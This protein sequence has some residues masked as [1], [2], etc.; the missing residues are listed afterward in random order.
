[1]KR[2]GGI[3]I[4][5]SIVMI[6]EIKNYL[7]TGKLPE[8]LTDAG[9]EAFLKR[10]QIFTMGEDGSIRAQMIKDGAELC[11]VGDD[12]TET[13]Q[14]IFDEV[15]VENGHLKLYKTWKLI[16]EEWFG[17]KKDRIVALME[18]CKECMHENKDFHKENI[19]GNT[20][21]NEE[22]EGFE[23]TQDTGKEK[24][25]LPEAE[26]PMQRLDISLIN[27]AE[28]KDE[29]NGYSEILHIID[30]H[31]DY[32][33]VHPL[34]NC[35]DLSSQVA[36]G[37]ERIFQEEGRPQCVYKARSMGDVDIS[38]PE[39]PDAEPIQ[40]VQGNI[41][42]HVKEQYKNVERIFKTFRSKLKRYILKSDNKKTWIH[43]IDDLIRG[44]NTKK[45]PYT[46]I[47]P[48]MIFKHKVN[49]VSIEIKELDTLKQ[50][51]SKRYKETMQVQGKERM[52]MILDTQKRRGKAGLK[53]K[54][55][56]REAPEFGDIIS[57]RKPKRPDGIC[58]EYEAG[59]WMVLEELPNQEGHFLVG[60]GEITKV[61]PLEMIKIIEK[62][63]F[64]PRDSS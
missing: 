28:F 6:E 23:D 29:N 61:V 1:M 63:I 4:K 25:P 37:L 20:S 43:V 47:T 35:I 57:I 53:E 49:K 24:Q 64:I 40:C 44:M 33:F 34:T 36:M 31:S 26:K 9:R 14:R 58:T 3:S 60:T 8:Y 18:K 54:T 21:E 62:N 16:K 12:D 7:T 17:F 46:D 56:E 15:H 5:L 2:H 10:S 42:V 30:A 38:F 41:K 51:R 52:K 45:Q 27:L 22:N 39:A 11:A 32:N 19:P 55:Q 13:I 59:T 50:Y 48:E